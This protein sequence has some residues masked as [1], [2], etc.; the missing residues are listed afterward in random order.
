MIKKTAIALLAIGALVFILG[1]RPDVASPP[2]PP[3]IPDDPDAEP[4]EALDDFVRTSEARFSNLRPG[5]EK[6]IHWENPHVR[7]KT[8]LS[9]VYV[10]GFT[11][12]RGE[13]AP[14]S[15]SLAA[16]LEANLFYTRLTGHGLDGDAMGEATLGDWQRDL[17]EA[18]AIGK[19][20]GDRVILIGTSMG[21]ALAT[22]LATQPDVTDLAALILISPG[23][24]L[25]NADNERQLAR[26]TRMPWGEHLTQLLAGTYRGEA[27]GDADRDL[28]WTRGY[29][30]DA[31]VML[32]ATMQR[33]RE[34]DLSQIMAPTL[35]LYSPNDTVISPR[36]VEVQFERIGAQKKRLVVVDNVDDPYQHVLAGRILS[37]STTNDVLQITLDF[38]QE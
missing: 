25:A 6:I 28:Y 13:T 24:A 8:P 10:H 21:G 32:A 26:M 7:Q 14:F 37:P 11:A 20:L 27:T 4:G 12:S 5:T 15:D 36:E 2:A 23:Y 19:R 22:W 38:L 9:V 29:R 33:A 1:P 3:D 34:A 16:R 17:Y 31:L 30:S 18:Y 35:V